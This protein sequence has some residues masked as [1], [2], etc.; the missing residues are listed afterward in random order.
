MTW[1]IMRYVE[2]TW[3]NSVAEWVPSPE[4]QMDGVKEGKLAFKEK[5]R[6]MILSHFQCPMKSADLPHAAY[7]KSPR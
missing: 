1:R 4:L 2:I 6:L 3:A 7:T 5:G